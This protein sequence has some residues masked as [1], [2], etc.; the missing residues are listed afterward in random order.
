MSDSESWSVL[1]GVFLP[2]VISWLKNAGW[3]RGAKIGLAAALALVVGFGTSFFANQLIFSWQ[4]AIVNTAI[5]FAA[6][7]TVY[8]TILERTGLEQV[9]RGK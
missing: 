6:A 7:S 9:L 5:V 3:P 8:T 1:L 4:K 2:I